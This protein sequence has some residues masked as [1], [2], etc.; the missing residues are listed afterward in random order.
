MD[1]AGPH[2]PK[3]PKHGGETDN[4]PRV[5]RNTK[6]AKTR[7][8]QG[9]IFD[10]Q[11]MLPKPNIPVGGRL[12][13]FKEKWASITQDSWALQI[14]RK[15]YA[16][17]LTLPLRSIQINQVTN[18]PKDPIKKKA[19]FE[20]I[21]TLLLKRVIKEV[22]PNTSRI[23]SPVFLAEKRSGGYRLVLNVKKLNKFLPNQT[24]K[25][26]GLSSILP[27]I[28]SS[29]WAATIDL[30]DA[31]Y[32]VPIAK[33]SQ[34]MLGFAVQDKHFQFRALPF[35]L[36]TAPRI[37]T[38]L[39][40][41]VAAELRKRG[42]KIFCYLDDWI[43]FSPSQSD[44]I[45]HIETTLELATKLGLIIN[46]KKSNLTPTTQPEFLGAKINIPK[47]TARPAD[48]RIGK[49]IAVGQELISQDQSK[50][51][52]WLTFLGL[53][54][55]LVDLVPLCRMR[56]RLLQ[57]HLLRFYKPKHHPLN[58][59]IPLSQK[60]SVS[61]QK[62][63]SPLTLF[64]GKRTVSPLPSVTIVTDASQMGWGAHLGT[65]KIAGS[66]GEGDTKLHINILEMKAVQIALIKFRQ[67]ITNQCV[68][69]KSDN[70]TVVSYINRQGGTKSQNLCQLSIEIL[71]WCVK[72]NITLKACHIPGK[73]NYI[74]DF[75]SR[76]SYLPT[77]WQL[78]KNVVKKI[79]LITEK[80]QIDL[81]AS[82][83]NHQ[84]PTYCAKHQ[85]P[86]AYA[87]DAFS[88]PWERILGYAFPPFAIIMKVLEK[89]ISDKATILL[90][91]PFWPRRP[92]FT[93][94]TSLLIHNP[95][96]LPVRRDLLRQ[97]GTKTFFPDPQKL[98]LTL[99]PI[100]GNLLRRQ[101]F[102]KGLQIWQPNSSEP[103]PGTLM[104]PDCTDSTSGAGKFRL[105]RP[106]PL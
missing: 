25:M 7:G 59:L 39:I 94:L 27:Y 76:G 80:P 55:S 23:I 82:T 57:I 30:K 8:T 84:L 31:Y 35:G 96:T 38:R 16:P 52:T 41:V 91:A 87:T 36:R 58:K 66:W 73:D 17:R 14:I 32:H 1:P 53:L 29:D 70:S 13:N 75:L 20:E 40:R 102:Q 106:L 81:F 90:I 6:K 50:A 19:L 42:I 46:I 15:G 2:R 54:S 43:I 77:E 26:E 100:S 101:D 37:F 34:C 4:T 28:N 68:L 5:I 97:P 51:K 79:F 95:R 56:M 10:N 69:I 64:Q 21:E 33:E 24:F 67:L 44:L 93:L 61:I 88:I 62:W 22:P 48:H 65:T 49:V 105:T 63:I 18:L 99:W 92:W 78:H 103:A 47:L 98:S 71:E 86:L 60:T 74:A 45:R 9:R 104:I 83:L 89:V 85:D 72:Y 3:D 11:P 12:Q